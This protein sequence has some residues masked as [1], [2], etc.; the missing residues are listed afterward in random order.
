MLKDEIK[1][2]GIDEISDDEKFMLEEND[3]IREYCKKRKFKLPLADLREI[4]R[5]GL[6]DAYE[7]WKSLYE[8]GELI[9]KDGE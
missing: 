6:T 1:K 5:R 7:D 4:C 2:A 9:E 3:F 8:S